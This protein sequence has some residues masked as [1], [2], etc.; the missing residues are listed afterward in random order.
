MDYDL[1]IRIAKKARL[2]YI[3]EFISTYR[4][5][6][7]SKTVSDFHT[8]KFME[9]Y[10]MTVMKYYQTAPFNRVYGYCYNVVLSKLP[11]SLRRITPLVPFFALML[12]LKEY[13]KLNRGIR[14][15]DLKLITPRN[16]KKLFCGADGGPRL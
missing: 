4:L 6:G 12:S 15:E 10:L 5:H 3:P 9:E 1:W 16:V 8:L 2:E 7:K 14:L 13:V 11:L